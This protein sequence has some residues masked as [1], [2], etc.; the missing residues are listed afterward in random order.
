MEPAS[1]AKKEEPTTPRL[2]LRGPPVTMETRIQLTLTGRAHGLALAAARTNNA[3]ARADV[4]T[5]RAEAMV[6]RAR[7]LS[8]T[9][10][11]N[12][13]GRTPSV[14][15]TP[16]P[17]AAA[18]PPP[19]PA[20]PPRVRQYGICGVGVFYSSYASARAAATLLGMQDDSKIMVSDNPDKLE[21]WMTGKPFVGEDS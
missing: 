16:A 21:V 17:A 6:D 7:A 10:A 2:N 14:L 12:N 1:P 19:P 8:A 13:R 5:A 9:P 11:A 20:N 4:T 15:V 3:M 18:A